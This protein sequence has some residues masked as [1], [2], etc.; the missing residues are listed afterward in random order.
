MVKV[1]C[2][3][4]KK[5]SYTAAPSSKSKCAYCNHHFSDNVALEDIIKNGFINGDNIAPSSS[6]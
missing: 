3:E 2:P 5:I 6:I 4:C 1:K